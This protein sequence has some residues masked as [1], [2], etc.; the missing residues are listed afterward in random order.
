MRAVLAVLVASFV[1]GCTSMQLDGILVFGRL[2]DVSPRDIRDAVATLSQHK[3][4]QVAVVSHDEI[5]L[6]FKPMELGWLPVRRAR[7][8]TP[9]TDPN[10]SAWYPDGLNVFAPAVLR[11]IRTADEVY[12]FPVLN[13]LKPTRDN[14]HLRLLDQ[15]ASREIIR[16][17]GPEKNW[18]HGAYHLAVPEPLPTDVGLL[19]RGGTNELVLFFMDYLVEGTLGGQ[20]T[21]GLNEESQK[22]EIWKH[23][24]AAR[25]LATK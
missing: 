11:A 9:P 18:W 1:S 19:F 17:L 12:V 24:Y 6:Y 13:P 3:V 20:N 14:K 25:E 15:E 21:S 5:H 4:S 2:Q 7:F 16:L 8:A 10:E 23:R 22:L